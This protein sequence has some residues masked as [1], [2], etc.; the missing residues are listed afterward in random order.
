[1]A[2]K[3]AQPINQELLDNVSREAHQNPRRRKNY[4]FHQP[5]DVIQR[6]LNAIE[7]DSYIRPHRHV[8]PEKEEI[9]LV[10]K[11]KGAVVQFDELGNVEDVFYMDT[12]KG[13]W[14]VDIP[15]G[16]FHTIVSLEEKSV[17]YE[18]KSGPYNPNADKGFASWAPEEKTQEAKE[19]LEFL[20]QYIG[21]LYEH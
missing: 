2:E 3:K 7:P 8:N 20:T 5:Q 1:M 12:R 13:Q 18:I 10:L 16:V 9:F 6:F 11:G 17:F 15:G 19:Y 14:G 21:H 4:N